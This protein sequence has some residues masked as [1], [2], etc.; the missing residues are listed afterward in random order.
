[1][2]RGTTEATAA[3]GTT[4]DVHG[5]TITLTVPTGRTQTFLFTIL[6]YAT[7]FPSGGVSSQGFYF[8]TE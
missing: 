5:V 2:C 1:M 7:N 6:G 3:Q 8:S 4:I